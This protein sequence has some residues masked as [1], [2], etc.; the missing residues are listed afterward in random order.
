MRAEQN[1]I[2]AEPADA[3]GIGGDLKPFVVLIED[4]EFRA[5]VDCES[6]GGFFEGPAADD[7]VACN[8]N[9]RAPGAAFRPG[10]GDGS[11]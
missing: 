8:H 6:R 5:V 10:N 4:A 3:G 11:K 2:A 7:G 9:G 1:L